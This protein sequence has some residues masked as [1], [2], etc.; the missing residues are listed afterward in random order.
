MCFGMH[1]TKLEPTTGKTYTVLNHLHIK[2]GTAICLTYFALKCSLNFFSCCTKLLSA[3]RSCVVNV[4]VFAS[5][6]TFH[7]LPIRWTGVCCATVAAFLPGISF[8]TTGCVTPQR[9]QG[10]HVWEHCKGNTSNYCKDNNLLSLT[11]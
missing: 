7:L 8:T 6:A 3:W 10:N 5:I 2:R 4:S 1:S 9:Q 11:R